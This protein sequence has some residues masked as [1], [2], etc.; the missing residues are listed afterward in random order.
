MHVSISRHS[1]PRNCRFYSSGC[2]RTNILYFQSKILRDA[3]W[4]DFDHRLFDKFVGLM[5]AREPLEDDLSQTSL[6][7]DLNT[8]YTVIDIRT[9]VPARFQGLC[10]FTNGCL[11]ITV[12]RL[13]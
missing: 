1:L 5:F 2:Q 13:V 10:I 9:N 7:F 6:S 12:C 11:N 3:S 8:K 4:L